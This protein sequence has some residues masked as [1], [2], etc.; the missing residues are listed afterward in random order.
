MALSGSFSRHLAPGYRD[1]VGTTFRS[2]DAF[3][4]RIFSTE[5]TT[6]SYEDYFGATGIPRA[7]A[8]AEAQPIS[9]YDPI[10]G[11]SLRITPAAR[12]IGV[13][14]SRE[15][16]DD[17]LY[18]NKSALRKSAS[19]LARAAIEDVEVQAA[20]VFNTFASYLGVDG[21]AWAS[22]AHTRLDGGA[23]QANRPAVDAALSLTSYRNALLQFDKWVDDRGNKIRGY[24]RMLIVPTDL[25]HRAEEIVTSTG[26]PG[27]ADNDPNV[28]KNATS[29]LRWPYLTSTTAWGVLGSDHWFKWLWR[30]RPEMDSYDD[31]DKKVAKFTIWSRFGY[32]VPHWHDSYWTTGA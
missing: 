17:D 30:T 13:Q 7:V 28:T 6:R 12:A 4:S 25:I 26:K 15:A 9:F 10:E 21:V 16:W 20:D 14:I 24:P 31:R 11:S 8:K 5:T 29:I 27:T 2:W 23:N 32:G 18:K 3:Y 22:T 19:G 1:I